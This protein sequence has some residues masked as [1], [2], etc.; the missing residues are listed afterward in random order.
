M[1]L[2]ILFMAALLLVA[3]GSA[4]VS[5]QTFANLAD[6]SKKGALGVRRLAA[7]VPPRFCFG[8]QTQI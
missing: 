4:D 1:R 2:I 7:K 6:A 5:D 8:D 3:C